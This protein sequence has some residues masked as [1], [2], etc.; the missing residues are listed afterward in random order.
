MSGVMNRDEKTND[1]QMDRKFVNEIQKIVPSN[2]MDG[3]KSDRPANNSK[4]K[5]INEIQDLLKLHKELDKRVMGQMRADH[6]Q[7]G[8]KRVFYG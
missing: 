3:Y 1:N 2:M 6:V 7:E 4:S 8:T 5:A